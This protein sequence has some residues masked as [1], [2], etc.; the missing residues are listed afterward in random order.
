MRFVRFY[1]RLIRSRRGGAPTT[2]RG[3]GKRSGFS[4]RY[5]ICW[6]NTFYPNTKPLVSL[7]SVLSPN[8]CVGGKAKTEDAGLFHGVLAW[9]SLISGFRFLAHFADVTWGCVRLAIRPHM[10][11]LIRFSMGSFSEH[12]LS[13]PGNI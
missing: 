4:K 12:G 9:K 7:K 2:G 3:T 11:T 10:T 13:N 6:P 8:Q 5:W 1:T